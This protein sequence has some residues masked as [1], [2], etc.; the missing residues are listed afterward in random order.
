IAGT[1]PVTHLFHRGDHRQPKQAIAPGD[2]TIAAAAGN[3]AEIADKDPNT[4]TSGR[5]LALAR[6][7]MSGKHPLTGRVLTNPTCRHHFG[8]GLVEAPGVFG[9]LGMRPTH[10]ELLDWLA[11][12]FVRQGWSLKRMHR[13]IM[14]SAVYRQS[15]TPVAQVSN[16][17][18]T[19]AANDSSRDPKSLPL[20]GGGLGGS[21]EAPKTLAPH[22]GPLPQRGEGEKKVAATSELPLNPRSI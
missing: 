20:D 15:S 19:G 21:D 1:L 8:W 9:V 2:L 7:L 13:L 11:D 17:P 10:A 5:R 18:A 16:R 6:H 14:T 12:E 4:P 3:R 22:P